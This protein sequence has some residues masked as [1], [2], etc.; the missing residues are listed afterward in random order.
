M[1][2]SIVYSSNTGN[3]RQLAEEIEKQLPAGELVYCGAPDTA[4]LQAEVL[5]VGFW[6]DKGS[7]DEKVAELL[8]QADGKTVYL[9][10]TAG[11]G[12][13]QQYFDQILARVRE[14]LPAGAVYG[15]GFMCQGRMPQA[16]RSRY[17]AMQAKEPENARY[18]MLIENFDAALAH[19]NADD[20]EAATAWAKSCLA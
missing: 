18:K 11:F 13:S 20:L 17:E 15:G 1:R 19:P 12:Q 9:F 7:C 8:K 5:F 3:T 14:N 10:G 16:V 6:T 4:A 2:Y